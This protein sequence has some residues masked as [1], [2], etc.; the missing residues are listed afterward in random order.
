MGNVWKQ[1]LY[2]VLVNAI[3]YPL[4]LTQITTD[5]PRHITGDICMTLNIGSPHNRI[6]VEAE[7][8]RAGRV[9]GYCLC[10]FNLI[11]I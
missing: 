3:R 8:R 5:T 4:K 7:T 11:L 6:M 2:I 1:G 9:S 10:G